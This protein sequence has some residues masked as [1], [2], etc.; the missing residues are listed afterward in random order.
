METEVLVCKLQT[1]DLKAFEY[2]YDQFSLPIHKIIKTATKDND[3]AGNMLHD[4]FIKIYLNIDEFK[5]SKHSLLIWIIQLT[6]NH[7]KD[8]LQLSKVKCLEM[9]RIQEYKLSLQFVGD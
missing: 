2:L 9:Y 7:I 8:T 6:I 5:F 1:K 4:V 3:L